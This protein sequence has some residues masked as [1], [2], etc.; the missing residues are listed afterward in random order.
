[1]KTLSRPSTNLNL[2]SKLIT[3][4]GAPSMATASS[5]TWVGIRELHKRVPA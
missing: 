3:N 5:L 2:F 4:L 1:M